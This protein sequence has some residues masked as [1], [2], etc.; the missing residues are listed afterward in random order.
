M[1]IKFS[2]GVW[3]S[4]GPVSFLGLRVTSTMTVLR[5]GDR[6]L[7]VHSPLPL[8]AERLVEV[9]ALGRVTDLYAP[10][11]FHHKWLGD[12]IAAFPQARVH[13]PEELASKRPDLRIDRFHDRPG[14]DA[15]F[16]GLAEI[17]IRGFRLRETALVHR[18]GRVA[19]VA[20]LVHNIG[21]PDHAWTSVYSRAMGFHDRVALSRFLRWTSF[22][23]RG[24]ARQSVD[25][26]L[27]HAYDRLI[28]GR[29]APIDGNAREV[30]AAAT[31]WLPTGA[32][33]RL[34]AGSSFRRFLKPC[35]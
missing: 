15:G 25:E 32:S 34:A 18:A 26:L 2:D 16:D 10:N 27:G 21:R 33:P 6:S 5:L 14:S 1:L 12:W 17:P 28:V 20:D 8:T 13:A 7:L 35:G 29:G 31:E 4:S 19:V 3:I 30:L 22:D 9:S 24:A 11:T 23:D